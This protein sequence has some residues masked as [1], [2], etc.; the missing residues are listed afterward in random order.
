MRG[1]SVVGPARPRRPG[2]EP[3]CSR[4]RPDIYRFSPMVAVVVRRRPVWPY[5]ATVRHNQ[6]PMET[7]DDATGSTAQAAT[8]TMT[9]WSPELATVLTGAAE[10]ARTA[11]IEHSGP[12]TVGDYLGVGYE[13]PAR[14]PH[15]FL[16]RLPGYEG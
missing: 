3:G 13:D 7:T 5:L 15:R 10:L 1:C 11:I 4:R 6:R 12:E 8:A 9:E 16:A 2:A 14:A